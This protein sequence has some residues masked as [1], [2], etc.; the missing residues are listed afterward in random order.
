M[1]LQLTD[2]GKIKIVDDPTN[3]QYGVEIYAFYYAA[4]ADGEHLGRFTEWY[5]QVEMTPAEST[6]TAA[7]KPISVTI[8]KDCEFTGKLVK[9]EIDRRAK[10]GDQRAEVKTKATVRQL[11]GQ[12]RTEFVTL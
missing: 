6:A 7:A 8:S 9:S 1:V 4:Y 10:V 12:P 3:A 11:V 2:A 5:S